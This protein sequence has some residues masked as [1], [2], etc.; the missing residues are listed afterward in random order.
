MLS[1]GA[2]SNSRVSK[3]V[4]RRWNGCRNDCA[5]GEMKRWEVIPEREYLAI[6][7][8]NDTGKGGRVSGMK[9]K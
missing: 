7:V 2:C 6:K 1:E 9:T 8:R 3:D 5:M 4:K